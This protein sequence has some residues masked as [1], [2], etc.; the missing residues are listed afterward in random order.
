MWLL[1]ILPNEVMGRIV[2]GTLA[3][4][5]LGLSIHVMT[6]EAGLRGAAWC[7][8]L[9]V[10]AL[11]PCWLPRIYVMPVV[12][13]GVL[14]VLS[15]CC[16]AIDK[17]RWGVGLGIAALFVRELALPYCAVGVA[18]ALVN[19]RWREAWLWLAGFL[20]YGIFYAWHVFEVLSLVG[21]NDRAYAEGWLQFGGAA[22]VISL[23]QMNAFLLLL[24]QWVTAIVLPLAMLGFAG[25]NTAAGRRAGFTSCAFLILFSLRRSAFQSI[26]G[27]VVRAA[28]LFGRCP[29][30]RRAG[31]PASRR[32]LRETSI[33]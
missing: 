10:G 22:F 27:L 14:I 30:S 3:A 12:W 6:K 26:L 19:R 31:R 11:M 24:P 21:P 18:L 28:T 17:P 25:W 2:I 13:A 1:G 23:A 29:S 8:L 16:F 7:G 32:S 4:L 15:W 5:L 20:A 33:V 9:L